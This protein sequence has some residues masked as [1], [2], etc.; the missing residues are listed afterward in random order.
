MRPHR[1]AASAT[2]FDAVDALRGFAMVWMTAFHFCFDLNH[3]GYIRQN[4]Y[5]DPLWTWQRTCILGLFLFTAGVGQ[6]MAAQ[7]GQDWARFWRRWVQVAGCA[8]LVTAGSWWMYPNSFI[9]FGTLHGIAVMLIVA[10]LLAGSGRWLWLLGGLLIAIKYIAVYVISTRG[11]PEFSYLLNSPAWN[12]IGLVTRK[13]VTEDYVP[14]LPWLGVMLWGVAAGNWLVRRQ[15][16][17]LLSATLAPVRGLAIL[18]RWSL[19][20]YMLHQPVMIGG[21]MIFTAIFPI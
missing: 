21:L 4:F 1:H 7:Q 11:N 19:T 6:A 17:W 18:G 16:S 9:Y 3:F 12:W 8:L 14:L 13:P 5:E 10:R 15:P 20:Y 2:R